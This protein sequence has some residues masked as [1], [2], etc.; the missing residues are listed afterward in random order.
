MRLRAQVC[1]RVRSCAPVCVHLLERACVCACVCLR[2]RVCVRIHVRVQVRAYVSMHA[3]VCACVCVCSCVCM[4]TCACVSMYV[5]VRVRYGGLGN[6]RTPTGFSGDT[7]R[8][9]DTLTYEVGVAGIGLG[10]GLGLR[11]GSGLGLYVETL[12]ILGYDL[13]LAGSVVAAAVVVCV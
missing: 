3:C 1:V 6:H 11:L 4:C 9:W 5:C 13:G 8:H 12:G 7:V 10:L 2:A